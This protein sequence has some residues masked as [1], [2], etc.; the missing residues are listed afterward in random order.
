MNKSQ[1]FISQ[2]LLA[3]MKEKPYKKISV[4]DIAR[5]AYVSRTTFYNHFQS[6]DD[7]LQLLI[8]CAMAPVCRIG[9]PRTA[10]AYVDY[11]TVYLSTLR[12]NR[13]LFLQLKRSD[14]LDLVP[15]YMSRQ[16]LGTLRQLP[17][18]KLHGLPEEPEL[19][20]A[21]EAYLTFYSAFWFLNHASDLPDVQLARIISNS[22]RIGLDPVS[23]ADDYLRPT[24]DPTEQ[25]YSG[26]ARAVET[27]QMLYGALNRLL[28]TQ[29]PSEISISEL[30]QTAGVARCSFYRHY[31]DIDELIC[32]ELKLIFAKVAQQIP[33]TGQLIGYQ[34][35]LE[36]L[37]RGYSRYD[38]LF[39][40]LARNNYDM[41]VLE[42]YR[43]NF[44]IHEWH[45]PY[46]IKYEPTDPFE[47]EYYRWFMSVEH[48]IPIMLYFRLNDAPDVRIFASWMHSYRYYPYL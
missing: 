1:H 45:L 22:R 13:E 28:E 18:E 35:V 17:K 15:D 10:A 24:E 23:G 40:A 26:D 12:Q 47:R 41:Q 16:L 32:E 4:M 21:Y 14:V 9:L 3:L 44:D 33:S 48:M 37:M 46:I 43:T 38:S 5:R 7:I 30:A 42:V 11:M 25:L 2:A 31:S 27:R 29:T 8:G 6:K 34:A 39:R 36:T 19:F 20:C